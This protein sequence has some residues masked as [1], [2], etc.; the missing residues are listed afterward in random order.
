[1]V[2]LY[3]ISCLE[4]IVLMRT[5]QL[6]SAK[7]QATDQ[8]EPPSSEVQSSDDNSF[9]ENFSPHGTCPHS[10]GFHFKFVKLFVSRVRASEFEEM[11]PHLKNYLKHFIKCR[12]YNQSRLAF[13]FENLLTAKK[14][15][16]EWA[17]SLAYLLSIRQFC[18]CRWTKSLELEIEQLGT[19][20]V[21]G[22]DSK[23]C[24]P[25]SETF[26]MLLKHF[27]A[28]EAAVGEV[29]KAA[30][31]FA[32][33]DTEDAHLA[34][35]YCHRFFLDHA[36]GWERLITEQKSAASY[37]EDYQAGVLS[38]IEEL[39]FCQLTAEHQHDFHSSLAQPFEYML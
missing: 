23:L 31:H 25:D 5:S 39:L 13:F 11:M 7:N 14:S 36:R 8:V 1:M 20:E 26:D 15:L 4:Q 10:N 22:V 16:E 9:L 33:E 38:E 17:E 6:L 30:Q 32:K 12:K 19:M 18:L 2:L 34:L 37:V 27:R 29:R 21:G 35:S 3:S 24:V 28:I